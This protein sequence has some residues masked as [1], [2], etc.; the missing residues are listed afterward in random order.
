[1]L[2]AGELAHATGGQYR[3]VNPL[4]HLLHLL[5]G[6]LLHIVA[7]FLNHLVKGDRERIGV[8]ILDGLLNLGP[9]LIPGQ[10]VIISHS[11]QFSFLLS[12]SFMIGLIGT[13]VSSTGSSSGSPLGF[14]CLG[15][16]EN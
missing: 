1:L 7:D 12:K 6:S 14:S 16:S 9:D 8:A 13:G 15:A 5:G 11:G 4:L 3:G 2:L 10:S